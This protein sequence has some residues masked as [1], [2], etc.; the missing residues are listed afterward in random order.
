VSISEIKVKNIQKS[1]VA[2]M[3]AKT[4]DMTIG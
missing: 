2:E 4:Y 1:P 3:P